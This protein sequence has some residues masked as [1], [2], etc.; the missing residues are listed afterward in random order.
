MAKPTTEIGREEIPQTMIRGPAGDRTLANHQLL[1]RVATK[2]YITPAPLGG[3]IEGMG[4]AWDR[5]RKGH[6]TAGLI[7]LWTYDSNL[8]GRASGDESLTSRTADSHCPQKPKW[9]SNTQ[10]IQ[11]RL[12]RTGRE[13]VAAL[14]RAA[15]R[16]TLSN[17]VG[18]SRGRSNA[19]GG[20][21]RQATSWRK[22]DGQPIRRN[23]DVT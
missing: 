13:G 16:K 7:A 20:L 2:I 17:Q 18:D 9:L 6:R 11:S 22:R 10:I 15:K 21:R 14:G 4:S 8:V 12:L 3:F 23:R 1:R 19:I 5:N